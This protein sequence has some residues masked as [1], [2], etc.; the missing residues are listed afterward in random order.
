[1]PF[2]RAPMTIA[3]ARAFRAARPSVALPPP[4]TESLIRC[5]ERFARWEDAKHTASMRHLQP[6]ADVCEEAFSA[7][8]RERAPVFAVSAFPVQHGKTTLLQAF[9]LY[10]LRHWPSA[11]IGYGSFNADRAEGKMLKVRMAAEAEGIR[12][13]PG[14]ATLSE[15]WTEAG[16]LVYAGGIVGGKW[17]G[18]GFDLL[19]LDDLYK[20]TEEADSPAHRAKVMTQIDDSIMT[21]AQDWTSVIVNM[22]RWNPHDAS[23]ELVKRGWRYVCRPAIDGDGEALAPWMVS[24][25]RLLALRD[26][27]PESPGQPRILA[28]PRRTWWSLYQG[29]PVPETGRIFE[30]EQLATYDRLPDGAYS[31]AL[32]LDLAYGAQRQHDR[33]AYTVFRRYVSDPRRLYRV[34]CDSR[35]TKVELYSARIGEAQ[36]RRGGGIFTLR[37]RVPK[38]MIEIAAWQELL[39]APEVRAARRIPALWYRNTV[40]AGAADMM[41]NYGAAVEGRLA[42]IDKLARAQAG[43][44]TSAWSE[45]R[46][47][48]PAREDEHGERW[49]IAHEG[50]TGGEGCEDDEV[51]GA[52][53]AHDLL[54]VP[55]ATLGGDGPRAIGLHAGREC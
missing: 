11:K 43:G 30:P 4:P 14:R 38:S 7:I 53:A 45:G 42:K 37:S 36:L 1:M 3:A 8:R 46:I 32:G 29:S 47:V 13:T 39:R 25:E 31:E 40:E 51:D 10:V 49:R 20:G 2:L 16:G 22:A 50:F 26:G 27:R 17:T 34:E 44:Y 12:L 54:A 35:H 33:S 6:L 19:I 55:V 28:I 9:V 24:K 23:G 48:V 52:V 21:R 41:I 18:Q 5:A 15:W